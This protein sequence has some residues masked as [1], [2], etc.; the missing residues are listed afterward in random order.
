MTPLHR[1]PGVANERTSLAWQ[2]TALSTVAGAAIMV[3]LVREGLSSV[4]LPLLG[5][6]LVLSAVVLLGEHLR[7]RAHHAARRVALGPGVA[8]AALAIALALVALTELIALAT[9][10]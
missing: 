10:T 5:A 1:D 4:A 6:A 2:R 7:Y 3:R 9:A 8:G